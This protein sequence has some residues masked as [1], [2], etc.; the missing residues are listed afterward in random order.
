[1]NGQSVIWKT[2]PSHTMPYKYRWREYLTCFTSYACLMCSSVKSI[3]A[4]YNR[5]IRQNYSSKTFSVA[6]SFCY[7]ICELRGAHLPIF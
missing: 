4:D 5:V 1:M 3:H 2:V 7:K 6:R